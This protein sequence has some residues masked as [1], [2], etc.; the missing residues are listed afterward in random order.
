MAVRFRAAAGT[1]L[2]TVR[3]NNEDSAVVSDHILILADGMG[4][5]A[6]GEVASVVAVRVFSELDHRGTDLAGDILAAGRR[7]RRALAAIS[8]ADPLVE[9]LG[10]TLITAVSDG[11]RVLVGHIGDSRVY[12][13]RDSAMYQVTTDHTHVQRMVELGQLSPEQA[14]IHPYRAML[15]KSLDDHSPGPDLDV[16]DLDLQRGDRLLLCSDGLSDYLTA[17]QIGAALATEDRDEAVRALLESALAAATRDNVTVIVADVDTEADADEPPTEPAHVGAVADGIQLSDEAAGALADALP[18]LH[19]DPQRPWHG[20]GLDPG[21]ADGSAVLAEEPPDTAPSPA[22]DTGA[23]A[24]GTADDEEHGSGGAAAAGTPSE[25]TFGGTE[26]PPT[27]DRTTGRRDGSPGDLSGADRGSSA[28]PG[29]GTLPGSSTLRGSS[30]LRGRGGTSADDGGADPAPPVW[31]GV[32]AAAFTAAALV[33]LGL[34]L[35]G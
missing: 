5:H 18:G 35:F 22:T 15:L 1:D 23:P 24:S 26:T 31:P 3:M 32:L 2:G 34:F 20:S 11:D 9:S 29:A 14:R 6:A 21:A 13:L 7:A 28:L 16:I 17:E 33:L 12:V 27:A 19:L 8:E 30:A 4:G 10:T 25:R